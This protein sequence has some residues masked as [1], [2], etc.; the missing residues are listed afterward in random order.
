MRLIAAF[1]VRDFY[2]DISYRVSFLIGILGAVFSSL[3]FYFL[4]KLIG[5]GA[6][7]LLGDYRGDYFSFVIIGVAFGSYF[8][9]GLTG[10]ARALRQAQTTGTLESMMMA[11]TPLPWIILGSAAWSYTYTTVR[12][13][14][15]MLVGTLILGMDVGGANYPAVF[16]GLVLSII[17]FASVGI[18]AAS[19]IMVIKRGDPL[20][21]L[22]GTL[23]N[24][25][26]GV[27][28][29]IEVMPDWLQLI[30]K[31]LPITY[32]LRVMRLA[33]LSSAT[34]QELAGD[35]FVL[36]LFC[37]ILF[38]LSLLTFRHAVERSRAD[39]S[40]SHY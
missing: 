2:T 4:S 25:V 37:L 22:F 5:E 20:T 30:A 19:I 39:G 15:Y 28:Y 18:M 23:A 7:A 13:V 17:T 26:G 35:M 34:W 31:L 11:P 27:F 21:A 32:A 40:L 6:S 10:F 36:G 24:L 14:I 33:L 29:P 3:V 9:V 1:L 16:V 12:V 38:P 8:G